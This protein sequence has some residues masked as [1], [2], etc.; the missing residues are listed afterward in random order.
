M[1]FRSDGAVACSVIATRGSTGVGVYTGSTDASIGRA[2]VF[3]GPHPLAKKLTIFDVPRQ[4]ALQQKPHHALRQHRQH[5]HQPQ[6]H[7]SSGSS[8]SVDTVAVATAAMAAAAAAAAVAAATA[9]PWVAAA[10]APAAGLIAVVGA[11]AASAA[12]LPLPLP[13]AGQCSRSCC[14]T[15]WRKT[16]PKPVEA[17]E[18]VLA[19][20]DA[21]SVLDVSPRSGARAGAC[22]A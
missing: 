14:P 15:T 17:H 19:D 13:P 12:P 21:R 16:F 7:R 4:L 3:C 2:R 6:R 20:F 18:Q 1:L 8:N 11:S 9:A 22:L 5:R 10:T